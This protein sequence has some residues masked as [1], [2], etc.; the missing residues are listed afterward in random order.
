MY[1]VCICTRQWPH[2]V[3]P[4]GRMD[5]CF[6]TTAWSAHQSFMGG[7][8]LCLGT[9]TICYQM[10]G[11]PDGADRFCFR[12]LWCIG[13]PL[14]HS[15][16]IRQRFP[17]VHRWSGRLTIMCSFTLAVTGM[18]FSPRKLAYSAPTFHLHSLQLGAG[19]RPVTVLVWPTFDALLWW[20]GPLLGLS[21]YKTVTLAR[22]KDF[23]SHKRWAMACTMV[24]YVVPLQR[25]GILFVE[26]VA[27]VLPHLTADQRA[28][29]RC[30][31]DVVGK[32]QAEKAAFALTGWG[33]LAVICAY[34][35]LVSN[36]QNNVGR[37][38]SADKLTK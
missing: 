18:I 21:A 36:P 20:I 28:F 2:H 12:S 11:I 32:A 16:R 24:G 15:K 29:L 34:A 4:C 1:T 35:M 33:A 8:M 6:W 23:V 5:D 30:P 7:Y 38:A 3:M 14:Q 37:M 10:A 25:V 17:S 22:A 27:A 26:I 19:P 9:Y 13:I 31:E